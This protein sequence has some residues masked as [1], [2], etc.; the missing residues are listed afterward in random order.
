MLI[1]SSTK[2]NS[3]LS[4]SL[5]LSLSLP[6]FLLLPSF[7]PIY[8]SFFG[9]ITGTINPSRRSWCMAGINGTLSK[10]WQCALRIPWGKSSPPDW[11]VRKLR[12]QTPLYRLLSR[13]LRDPNQP[14]P[15][16]A[17]WVLALERQLA[18]VHAVSQCLELT[19]VGAYEGTWSLLRRQT[20][21]GTCAAGFHVPARG[22][23]MRGVQLW[24]LSVLGSWGIITERS[25][26][27]LG[28]S[29]LPLQDLG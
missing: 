6:S 10:Y 26:C 11:W 8:S 18:P 25:V 28:T 27:R 4:P 17:R 22:R 29:F 3:S 19:V 7:L 2:R 20:V 9:P 16:P 24:G 13:T 5:F 21:S 12:S 23:V 15:P 1:K 14:S